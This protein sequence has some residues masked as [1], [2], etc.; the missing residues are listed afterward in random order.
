MV[1]YK[2][3][4]EIGRIS[5]HHYYDNFYAVP[6]SNV[7]MSCS[8]WLN[9]HISRHW[10][11]FH[12]FLM[13][14]KSC[15]LVVPLE[16]DSSI[17]HSWACARHVVEII[18]ILLPF[19]PK[20]HEATKNKSQLHEQSWLLREHKKNIFLRSKYKNFYFDKFIFL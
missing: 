16:S 13:W 2:W 17:T 6:S 11:A 7:Q 8:T 1:A 14:Q 4:T 12:D 18:K 3:I 9:T 15:W 5:I 19:D 10:L 20:Q